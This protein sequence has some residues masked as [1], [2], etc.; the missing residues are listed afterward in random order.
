MFNAPD[1]NQNKHKEKIIVETTSLKE[2]GA[3]VKAAIQKNEWLAITGESG[4]GKNT[5]LNYHLND[6]RQKETNTP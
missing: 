4:T 2:V 5:A 6:Y 3:K 1:I